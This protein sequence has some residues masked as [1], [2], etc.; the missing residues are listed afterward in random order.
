MK[1]FAWVGREWRKFSQI[2]RRYFAADFTDFTQIEGAD[3]LM[4]SFA[5][6]AA[7]GANLRELQGG[8]LA[9]D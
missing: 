5:W 1:S 9:T 3:Y 4:K 6:L 7:N 8:I 2:G